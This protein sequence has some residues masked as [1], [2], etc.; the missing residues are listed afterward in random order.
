MSAYLAGVTQAPLTSAVI[1]MELTDNHDFVLRFIATCLISR[2]FS[3]LVL[4][5]AIIKITFNATAAAPVRGA[6]VES[7]KSPSGLN[8]RIEK[9]RTAAS[10]LSWTAE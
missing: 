8:H 10:R 3:S 2:A 5:D 1:T 4:Q 9:R 6:A 7:D